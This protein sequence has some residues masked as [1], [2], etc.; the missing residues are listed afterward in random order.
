[1]PQPTQPNMGVIMERIS[2]IQT[3]LSEIKT[4]LTCHVEAQ[5]KF[6]QETISS[7][8]VSAEKMSAVQTTVVDHE[9]RLKKL[10]DIVRRLAVTDAILRWVA[11]ILMGSVITLIWGILTN[12]VTLNFP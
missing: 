5:T 2:N 8:L 1:M 10:E 4:L 7:R 6:E 11:V 9:G 12:Q 3:D